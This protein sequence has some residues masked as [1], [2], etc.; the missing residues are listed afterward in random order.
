L[1]KKHC[2]FYKSNDNKLDRWTALAKAN[3]K[4]QNKLEDTYVF[5]CANIG[6]MITGPKEEKAV[7]SAQN[8]GVNAEL[9]EE[10][11]YKASKVTSKGESQRREVSYSTLVISLLLMV[12]LW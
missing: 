9:R 4:A 11:S 8:T 1:K 6:D 5:K 3:L 7:Q 12:I 10:I 2:T